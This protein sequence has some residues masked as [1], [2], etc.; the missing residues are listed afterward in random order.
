MKEIYYGGTIKVGECPCS[1]N[2]SLKEDTSS[3]C[4]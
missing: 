2:A 3:I 1:A 4:A